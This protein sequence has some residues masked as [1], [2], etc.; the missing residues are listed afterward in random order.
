MQSNPFNNLPK[1]NKIDAI[2]ILRRPISEV[3]LLAD[4]YK[5]VFHLANFPCEESEMVL[6]D[7]IKYDCEKLEYKIAKRKAIEV[8]AN[9]G[10]KKAIQTIAEFLEND[11]DYLVETVIWSLG[12]LKCDDINIINKIC[13]KLYNQFNNKRVVIQTLTNLGVRKEID[14]IRSLSRDKKS[15][16]RVKG[17]SFAALI[18]LAGEEDK[19]GELKKFLRLSNQNDRHCAVQDIIN[20]GHLSVLPVLIKAPISPSFKLQAIDSLW[21]NELL[22]CENIKLFNCIDSVVVD[23]PNKIDTLE[24]NNFN[25]E[26]SFFVEQLFHTD[27]NRC[28]HSIKELLKFPLENV[29]YYL[30]NNWDRARSDYGAIYFFISVYKL[31]LDQQ[32]YDELLLDKVDFVLSDTWP[33]YMKFKSSAIQILGCLNENKFYN[34]INQFSDESKTPYWK[35]RYTALFVLQ[36]KQNQMKKDLAKLFLNDSHRFVRLKAKEISS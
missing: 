11:D 33:N 7:F 4:Y 10:C 5:A 27:F 8:L 19:L 28:Y 30:N 12:K 22:F 17:A 23:D 18:K 14:M 1:I 31:L 29:L 2:N 26:L 20:A 16:N 21:S 36:N 3:K 25:N 24:V 13:S 9:Y 6:L 15:S 32:L 34:N 35:N